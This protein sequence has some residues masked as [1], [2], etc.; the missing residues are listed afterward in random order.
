MVGL[1]ERE[2]RSNPV[3]LWYKEVQNHLRKGD[4]YEIYY[5]RKEH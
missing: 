4:V 2:A 3:S 5:Y 1:R